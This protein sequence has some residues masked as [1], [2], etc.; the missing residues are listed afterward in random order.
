LVS[1]FGEIVNLELQLLDRFAARRQIGIVLLA[2]EL[3]LRHTFGKR[4]GWMIWRS[5]HGKPNR[6]P[7]I[8]AD[9]LGPVQANSR[10]KTANNFQ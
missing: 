8:I 3:L 10:L 5:S 6:L 2:A 9:P 1:E 4:E 7:R